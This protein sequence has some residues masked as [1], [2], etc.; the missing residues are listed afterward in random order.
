MKRT[1]DQR[2]ELHALDAVEGPGVA[3]WSAK[4]YGLEGQDKLSLF[5]N[6]MENS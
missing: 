2:S 5:L 3:S 4:V 1:T 6:V